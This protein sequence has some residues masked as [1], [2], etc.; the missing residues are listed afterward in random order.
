MYNEIS[1][2]RDAAQKAVAGKMI[3]MSIFNK[4]RQATKRAAAIC[5]PYVII[6]CL[7]ICLCMALFISA[8]TVHISPEESSEP[9]DLLM[10]AS[11]EESASKEESSSVPKEESNGESSSEPQEEPK[12]ESPSEPQDDPQDEPSSEPND[13]SS[14]DPQDAPSSEPTEEPPK[15]AADDHPAAPADGEG[16]W[17]SD[18]PFISQVGKYP[19]G[20]ESVSAVMACQYAGISIDVETFIDE[21]LPKASFMK[22]DGK[23]IGYHPNQCFMGNPYE[24]NG[25]GC[26]APCIETAIRAFL[27][28][29]YLLENCTGTDLPSLCS[30]L[31]DQGIPVIIW[32]TMGMINPTEGS[33]WTLQETGETFQWISGEHCLVL[34]GYDQKYYYFNDPLKGKVKY[35]RETVE[36]RFSQMGLQSLAVYQSSAQDDVS[37]RDEEIAYD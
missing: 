3:M 7:C 21:Y 11:V 2:T 23:L 10:Q 5:R 35:K 34:T 27:P 9:E 15:G 17:L 8:A 32:A 28:D 30:Q 13:G 18:V 29:G 33:K 20:C 36:K 1:K 31:I 37:V 25:F 16:A 26:Y 24:K 19:T 12:E 22:E 4:I 6:V 14:S